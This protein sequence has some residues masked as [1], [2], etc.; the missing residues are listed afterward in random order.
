MTGIGEGGD[1]WK[2]RARRQVVVIPAMCI[3]SAPVSETFLYLVC[4]GKKIKKAVEDLVTTI[5]TVFSVIHA[6]KSSG[7]C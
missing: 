3:N 6:S 7:S 5:A 1:K 2:T 4:L